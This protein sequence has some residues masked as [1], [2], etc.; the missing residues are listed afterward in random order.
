MTVAAASL[1]GRKFGIRP[2]QYDDWL[3]LCNLWGLE[4]APVA[5]LKTPTLQASLVPLR[6]LVAKAWEVFEKE[7][8]D[9]AVNEMLRDREDKAGDR[10]AYLEMW[11]GKGRTHL[12]PDRARHDQ[13]SVQHAEHAW[14][15]PARSGCILRA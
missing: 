13:G 1:I 8:H 15:D 3:E 12:R 11:D 6:R 7:E 4:I 10:A 5:M 2:K 14:H 9:Y